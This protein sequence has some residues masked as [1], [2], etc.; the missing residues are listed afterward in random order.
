MW[1]TVLLT[2]LP[3]TSINTGA[4]KDFVLFAVGIT[5]FTWVTDSTSGLRKTRKWRKF[6]LDP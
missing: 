1:I 2:Q 6:T 4:G 3:R 5:T